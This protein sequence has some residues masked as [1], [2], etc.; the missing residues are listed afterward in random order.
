MYRIFSDML[1]GA[2]LGLLVSYSLYQIALINS[3]AVII[4]YAGY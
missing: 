3:G 1:R 2:I 4:R